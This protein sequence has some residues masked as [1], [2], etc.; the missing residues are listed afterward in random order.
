[1]YSSNTGGTRGGR[2]QFS[3][4]QVKD[5]KDRECYLGHSL[6]APIGRWQK[7]RD[8][9][10]YTKNK[11]EDD[12]EAIRRQ[13]QLEI[14]A[15]KEAEADALSEALG[16]APQK[17][18]QTSITEDELKSVLKREKAIEEV[19]DTE[20]DLKAREADRLQGLGYQA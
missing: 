3:W 11:Q 18:R 4:D 17:R 19:D 10:W 5:D 12:E 2:D 13:R 1:M 6:M 20:H 7:G 14:Q 9:L 15:I 16:F 8:L